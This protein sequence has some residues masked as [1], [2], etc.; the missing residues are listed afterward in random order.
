[1][2]KTINSRN[3]KSEIL[4]AYQALLKN[5][6]A[7]EKQ[8]KQLDTELKRSHKEM[9]NLK[10]KAQK[11]VFSSSAISVVKPSSTTSKPTNLTSLEGIIHNLKGI[12]HSIHQA[13]HQNADLQMVEAE[14]LAELQDKISAEGE[15]LTSLFGIELGEGQLD[16]LIA[17]YEASKV[18]FNEE[19]QAK[20]AAFQEAL[21]AKKTA[22]QEEKAAHHLYMRELKEQDNTVRRREQ[23]E[24]QYRLE[25]ERMTE[26]EIYDRKKKQLHQDLKDIVE[27][28]ELLWQKKEQAIDEQEKNLLEYEVAYE[29]LPDKLSAA[30]KRAEAEGT[31]IIKRQT[32][33]KMDLLQK[34]VESEQKATA[35]RISSLKKSIQHQ[36][37][38]IEKLT[39]QLE[40]ALQ[41]AQNLAVKAIEG[42]AN[43]NSFDAIRQIALE[44]A[45]NTNGKK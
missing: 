5:K 25:Q 37:A 15:Q 22:F 8:A 18:Q 14:M 6:N 35:L 24:H 33:I 34:E 17:D 16:K 44:Q 41:Q 9:A 42:V 3:T 1:M 28:Q 27:Q 2:A 39:Q 32:K 45:K 26:D 19:V 10:A 20:K 29:A 4:A 12:H 40:K 21:I 43:A 23:T 13:I 7:L 30:I 38:T 31:N 36:D 11:N